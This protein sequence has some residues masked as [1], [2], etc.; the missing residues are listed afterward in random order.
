M[1]GFVIRGT[2]TSATPV[3]LTNAY[4]ISEITGER[5]MLQVEVASGPI[6]APISDINEIPPTANIL[7]W[8]TFGSSGI[9]ITEFLAHWGTFLF[10]AEYSDLKYDKVFSRDTVEKFAGMAFPELGP[11]VTKRGPP[12]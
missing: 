9:P 5:K 6:L 1:L 10:H 2:N 3:Q 12:Q 8:V 7:L 11:H 4:I